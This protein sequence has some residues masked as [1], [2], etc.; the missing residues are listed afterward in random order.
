[1]CINAYTEADT[2]VFGVWL[3]YSCISK[4]RASPNGF[5]NCYRE[6]A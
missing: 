5:S 2:T 6:V 4:L 3:N 1:M